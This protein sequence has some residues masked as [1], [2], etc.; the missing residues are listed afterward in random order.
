M[1]LR[2]KSM[3]VEQKKRRRVTKVDFLVCSLAFVWF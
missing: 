3:V 1:K 2:R